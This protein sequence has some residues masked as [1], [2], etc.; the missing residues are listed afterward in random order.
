MTLKGQISLCLA[1]FFL[2][3]AGQIFLSFYQSGTVLRELD[4]QM[5]NFNAISRFQNGVEQSLS[6]MENYRWEYG[7]AKALTE[8]LNRA[9]SV[10]NA[11]L[12]RIQ[13]DIGTVS[14]EQYLLYNAVSTTY[15]SYTA[16][17]GQLEEAVASGEDAQAAQLYYN[18]IVPCGGYLRQYTQQL[19]NRA[20][21]DAQSTYTTVSA[22]SDRVKWAQTVVVA[23][24]LALGC[25]MALSVIH[26]LTPV[27]QLIGASREVTRGVFD[28]P[29]LPVPHQPEMAQLTE[30]FNHMKHSMAE[31]VTTLREKNEMERELHRQKTEALELQNRMER[32]RLQQLRSQIDPHF[33]FN[34]L[35]SLYALIRCNPEQAREFTLTLSKVY[36]HVLERRKQILSTLADEIDFTWQYY[37][38]QKIRFGDRI[39]LTTAID[40]ALRNWRIPAMSLQT[41]VENA[42]KHN[43]ITSCNPL[44]IRIRTEGESLLIENNFTPRSEGNAESLGVGLERIRSVYRFYTEENI[45]IASDSGTFRCRLPLLPPEK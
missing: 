13:G 35:N 12:W 33:L 39:E 19:L 18:K 4:D 44:H 37:S 32:S 9:F 31:Q 27:Q 43:R 29:D 2:A 3:L 24:C 7:D 1:A 17:V 20:I 40:P 6:A 36:R 14:E 25:V 26:L 41:L 5:G 28:S 22:L 38:L 11:W 15:G 23:L 42:L 30:A 16:L 45:S 10:T 21:A 8:E 34:S